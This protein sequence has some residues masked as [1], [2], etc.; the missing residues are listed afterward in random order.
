MVKISYKIA[1]I[2]IVVLTVSTIGFV[3]YNNSLNNHENSTEK[4]KITVTDLVGRTVTVNAPADRIVLT[5]SSHAVEVAAIL[6]DSFTEKIVGWDGDFEVNAGDAYAKYLEKYP[7]MKDIAVVAEGNDPISV[8]KVVA[9]KPDVVLMHIWQRM[10]YGDAIMDIVDK[11]DQAGIPTV[12]LDFYVDPMAN[13]TKSM[14]LMGKILGNEQRAQEIVDFY[15]QQTDLVYSRLANITDAKPNVY[16]EIASAT[17]PEY[18]SSNGDVAWGAIIKKA[19]G[20]NIAESLL[21]QDERPVSAEYVISKNPDIAI[22]T[23]QNW[24]TP[25]SVKLGYFTDADLARSIMTPWLERPGWETLNAVKDHKVYGI[26]TGYCYSIYNF[27]A[28]EAF[29]KWFYPDQFSDVDVNA[30]LA[31]FHARFQPIDYSGT[32]VFSYY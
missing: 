13:S 7:Q 11:L 17:P 32:F 19:G 10:Y 30:V 20:N 4:T 14:L 23:G 24:S 29:A 2:L 31:D 28:L 9:L 3:A 12:F 16:I 22:L 15:N 6:G 21:G 8:E 26:Y 5:E 18:G 27:V 1:A 25:G